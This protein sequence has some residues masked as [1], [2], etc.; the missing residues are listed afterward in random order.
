MICSLE[1]LKQA[2]SKSKEKEN[3]VKI[4]E[5]SEPEMQIMLSRWG[6]LSSDVS[7]KLG[8]WGSFIIKSNCQE[9]ALGPS[10]AKSIKVE[11]SIF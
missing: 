10:C 3:S 2:L 5:S 8:P 9:I 6:I 11:T 7:I 4:L 1:S